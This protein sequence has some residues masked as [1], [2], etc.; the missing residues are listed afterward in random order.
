MLLPYPTLNM[1]EVL[2]ICFSSVPQVRVKELITEFSNRRETLWLLVERAR[3]VTQL[4]ATKVL[5][6]RAFATHCA[7]CTGSC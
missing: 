1:N 3:P 5:E 6:R 7:P 4:S 2:L